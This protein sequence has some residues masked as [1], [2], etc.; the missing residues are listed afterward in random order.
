MGCSSLNV[1]LYRHH[2]LDTPQCA[3]GNPYEDPF[4][5]LCAC[6]RYIIERNALQNAVSIIVVVV[7]FAQHYKHYLHRRSFIIWKD[8]A[9][10]TW[11]IQSMEICEQLCCWLEYLARFSFC[12]HQHCSGGVKYYNTDHLSQIHMRSHVTT[13]SLERKCDLSL[14]ESADTTLR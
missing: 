1:H 9:S 6:P 8:D 12:F 10:L 5:Y 7:A 2:V 14:V 13:M 4:H 11:L 3:R